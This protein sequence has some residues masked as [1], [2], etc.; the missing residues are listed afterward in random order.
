MSARDE[1][2]MMFG[3]YVADE[4]SKRGLLRDPEP[5][6][7]D[8]PE[9]DF[10]RLW[11]RFDETKLTIDTKR[12]Y[13][14]ASYGVRSK[15]VN[16][17]NLAYSAICAKANPGQ[18]AKIS[19]YG[20]RLYNNPSPAVTQANIAYWTDERIATFTDWKFLDF[21]TRRNAKSQHTQ[22]ARNPEVLTRLV[23][24]IAT[25]VEQIA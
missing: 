25:E 12:G 24:C 20:G 18:V 15:I 22:L 14:L 7:G 8:V 17:L 2:T 21:N 3:E 9:A 4:L 6:A 11:Y 10:Y 5:V 19:R 23:G 1:V 13:R 16:D